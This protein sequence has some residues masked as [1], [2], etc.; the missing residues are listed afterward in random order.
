[1]QTLVKIDYGIMP[2]GECA[3]QYF[4]RMSDSHILKI[5]PTLDMGEVG[6][7]IHAKLFPLYEKLKQEQDKLKKVE[8]ASRK[9]VDEYFGNIGDTVKNLEVKVVF[10]FF[11]K[12]N[13]VFVLSLE[14]ENG[15]SFSAFYN[16]TDKFKKGETYKING[17][18]RSHKEY[19]GMKQT[20]LS[21]IEKVK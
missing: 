20:G 8:L 2:Y 15:H 14:D 1:M 17:I 5:V 6:R 18:I 3:G 10:T 9:P 19:R 21:K 12:M 11:I 7:A 4:E 13:G 16:G